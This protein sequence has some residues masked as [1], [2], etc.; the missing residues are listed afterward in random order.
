MLA[1]YVGSYADYTETV[2]WTPLPIT[3]EGMNRAL[4]DV[5]KRL[6]TSDGALA[7][8]TLTNDN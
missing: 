3:V 5:W 1:E 6:N 7:P 2:D 4:R 8:H